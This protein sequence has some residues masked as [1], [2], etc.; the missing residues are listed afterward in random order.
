M[1]HFV[2]KEGSR[3]LTWDLT[4]GKVKGPRYWC[5]PWDDRLDFLSSLIGDEETGTLRPHVDNS[6]CLPRF[7]EI[8]GAGETQ[9]CT[10]NGRPTIRYEFADIHVEYEGSLAGFD[11]K[12]RTINKPYRLAIPFIESPGNEEEEVTSIPDPK[13]YNFKLVEYDITT[14]PVK[15]NTVFMSKIY[16]L[17]GRINSTDW[18]FTSYPTNQCNMFG[19]ESIKAQQLLFKNVMGQVML[20]P[21]LTYPSVVLNIQLELIDPNGDGTWNKEPY[22]DKEANDIRWKDITNL[23]FQYNQ[24]PI[25]ENSDDILNLLIALGL[26]TDIQ[27]YSVEQLGEEVGD[28]GVIE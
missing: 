1:E 18:D 2:E 24:Y 7:V 9:Y 15:Y 6:I 10:I 3:K 27:M 26:N 17:I 25:E 28:S 19:L 23:E 13:I 5:G 8:V 4:T 21:G 16:S 12:F 20:V 11:I 14:P 22:F